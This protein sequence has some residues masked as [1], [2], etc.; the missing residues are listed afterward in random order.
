MSFEEGRPL[1]APKPEPTTHR[2]LFGN[3]DGKESSPQTLPTPLIAHQYRPE[4]PRNKLSFIWIDIRRYHRSI[5]RGPENKRT[6][7]KDHGDVPDRPSFE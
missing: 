7:T 3:P 1:L 2:Y 4:V 6:I 5:R